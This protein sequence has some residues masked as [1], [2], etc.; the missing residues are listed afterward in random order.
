M[1]WLRQKHS[2]Q[3]KSEDLKYLFK[4]ARQ[5]K[6]NNTDIVGMPCI[7]GKDRNIKVSLKDMMEEWK[8]YKENLLNEEKEWSGELNVEKNKGPCEKVCVKAV[9]VV[10]NLIKTKKAAVPSGITSEWLKVCKNDSIKNLGK[11]G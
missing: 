2:K 7:C 6:K 4:M 11:G 9:T 8:E 3:N 1:L 10:L 5:S